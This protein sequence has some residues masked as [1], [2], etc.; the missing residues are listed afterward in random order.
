VEPNLFN[1]AL[2]LVS[3]AWCTGSSFKVMSC[4]PSLDPIAAAAEYAQRR[5]RTTEIETRTAL[6]FLA[7]GVNNLRNCQVIQRTIDL[8]E[9]ITRGSIYDRNGRLWQKTERRPKGIKSGFTQSLPWR[10]PSDTCR[11]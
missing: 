4:S 2:V 8:L 5:E 9:T 3:R 11:V 7:E 6:T 1:L 10:M